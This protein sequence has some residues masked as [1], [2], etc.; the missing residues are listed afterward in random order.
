MTGISPAAATRAACQ[1]P[2]GFTGFIEAGRVAHR[3]ACAPRGQLPRRRHRQVPAHGDERGVRRF[4]QIADAPITR[5]AGQLAAFRGAPRRWPPGKSMRRHC[6]MTRSAA[7]PPMTQIER[8]LSR[9]VRFMVP[10]GSIS[11]LGA[12]W[13]QQFAGDD[14]ALDFAGAVPDALHAGIAPEA[15]DG[16]IV[17][18]A[19]CR[20]GSAPLRR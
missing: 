20:R 11:G 18:E 5:G 8:G 4:G 10:P 13:P 17:H 1:S 6:S 19:P 12:Q 16:Q 15:F 14:V 3:A 9:R 2:A 7:C